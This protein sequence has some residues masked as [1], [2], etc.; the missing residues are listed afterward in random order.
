VPLT[1]AL[2]DPGHVVLLYR[3]KVKPAGRREQRLRATHEHTAEASQ[4]R[5]YLDL[6]EQHVRYAHA[7]RATRPRARD[8][9]ARLRVARLVVGR[10]HVW[11][12]EK[13]DVDAAREAAP[14]RRC[15]RGE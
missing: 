14:E 7:A 10:G 11:W 8:A 3:D 4:K 13:Q 9:C 2:L 12:V 15:E 5:R 6:L 1:H